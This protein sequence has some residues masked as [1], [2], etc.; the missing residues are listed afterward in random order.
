MNAGEKKSTRGKPPK[1]KRK[2]GTKRKGGKTKKKYFMEGTLCDPREWQAIEW[3]ASM[4]FRNEKPIHVAVYYTNRSKKITCI[5]YLS[6]NNETRQY[7]I[8]NSNAS[9]KPENP[10]VFLLTGNKE[11]VKLKIKPKTLHNKSCY[12]YK[13]NGH[14]YLFLP[15]Q[16]RTYCELAEVGSNGILQESEFEKDLGANTSNLIYAKQYNTPIFS[17]QPA[18]WFFKE[19]GTFRYIPGSVRA[20]LD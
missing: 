12:L 13:N 18:N 16:I 2:G 15:S 8:P 4:H 1:K 17:T 3:Q 5:L 7:E 19:D 14:V 20:L 11:Q 9:F 10:R 6:Y